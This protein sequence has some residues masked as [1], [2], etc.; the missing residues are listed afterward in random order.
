MTAA[1]ERFQT[2]YAAD[3]KAAEAF[4]AYGKSSRDPSL[5]VPELAAYTAVASIVLN[6][7]ETVT[8]P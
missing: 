7:D 1:L 6:L 8:K 4:L 2:L 5:S 3:P